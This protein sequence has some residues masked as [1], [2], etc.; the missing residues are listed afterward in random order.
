MKRH[1]RAVAVVRAAS[2]AHAAGDHHRAG[3]DHQPLHGGGVALGRWGKLE[4]I[5]TPTPIPLE[6]REHGRP[7][8]R[9]PARS[10][11]C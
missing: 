1:P 6:L 8:R 7:T 11:R 3:D 10:S 9:R 4:R 2:T 5:A